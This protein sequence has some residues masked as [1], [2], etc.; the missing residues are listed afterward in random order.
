M[1]L[2]YLSSRFPFPS[3][4]GR[5]FMI[6]QHLASFSEISEDLEIYFCYFDRNNKNFSEGD[7]RK[8]I[9]RNIPNIKLLGVQ[10]L[11]FSSMISII[12]NFTRKN[13]SLQECLFYSD[14]AAKGI[15][16]VIAEHKINVVY[17]DMLRTASL[18]EGLTIKKIADLDDLLSLRYARFL[19]K[20]SRNSDLLGT[21]ASRFPWFLSLISKMFISFILKY[22]IEKISKRELIIANKFDHVCLVSPLEASNFSSVLRK[23]VFSIPPIMNGKNPRKDNYSLLNC[24]RFLFVGNITTNQNFES[25][26][27]IVECL[28][29]RLI[30]KGVVFKLDVIG[31]TDAR[32][33]QLKRGNVIFHGFVDDLSEKYVASD[34]LL[35]PIAFGSGIKVKIVEAISH[36]LP[37]ITNSIGAEGLPIEDN[38]SCVLSESVTDL[39][40][41]I[42]KYKNCESDVRKRLSENAFRALADEFSADSIHQKMSKLIFS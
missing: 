34:F 10:C 24:V 23:P 27:W 6:A 12:K 25:L 3:S 5:E 40:Y 11:P 21:Y 41:Q 31:K 17:C 35:A 20:S 37:V 30:E 38:I 33:N 1:K 8:T 36:G 14:G 18:V 42:L 32:V 9:E 4:G 13:L 39:V 15:E 26:K 22:E 2:L 19:E 16:A 7:Y 29:P 28:L